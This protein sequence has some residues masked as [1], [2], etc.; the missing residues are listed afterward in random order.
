VSRR[1]IRARGLRVGA[2]AARRRTS[3]AL[4]RPRP[5]RWP[6][7][8]ARPPC[9]QSVTLAADRFLLSRRP[10]TK[11][12]APPRSNLAAAPLEPRREVV[13]QRRHRQV[14]TSLRKRTSR[15]AARSARDL[16]RAEDLAAAQPRR[17]RAG[18][19][20]P[21]VG[22]ARESS[23]QA[24]RGRPWAEAGRRVGEKKRTNRFYV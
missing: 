1:G 17:R 13:E 12:C 18:V 11:I 14:R 3:S 4:P 10:P 24:V 21:P 8:A 7:I 20:L 19:A 2:S 15:G 23:T 22:G 16:A 5:Q 6:A 9:S